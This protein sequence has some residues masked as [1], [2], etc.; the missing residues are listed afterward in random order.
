MFLL[1]A[2]VV[3]LFVPSPW[4]VP[5]VLL[6]LGLFIGELVFWSRRVRGNPQEVSADTLVGKEA[7]VVTACRP[8]GQVRVGGE[9]WK[10]RCAEGADAGEAVVV[11]DRDE[12]RLVVER[13]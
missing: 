2:L 3:L 10:A 11:T 1:V 12:L 4:K 8:D 13:V 5:L 7:T 6:C 9:I